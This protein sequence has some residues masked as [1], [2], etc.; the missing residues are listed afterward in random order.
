M[1]DGGTAAIV[2]DMQPGFLKTH[3]PKSVSKMIENQKEILRYFV[4]HECPIVSLETM[5]GTLGSTIDELHDLI[6]EGAPHRTI[7]KKGQNAF[8]S[9]DLSDYL[10]EMGVGRILLMGVHASICV[11]NTARGAIHRNLG[12]IASADL[13][14]DNLITYQKDTDSWYQGNGLFVRNYRD[15]FTAS[16]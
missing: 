4:S 13:M 9:S 11:K 6:S 1:I 14:G 16:S 10:G 2:I 15:L 3:N 5:S 7:S 12:I 8:F